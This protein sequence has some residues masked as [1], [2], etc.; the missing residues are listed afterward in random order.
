[1][2]FSFS[3]SKISPKTWFS[4]SLTVLLFG[5]ILVTQFAVRTTRDDRSQAASCAGGQS[6]LTFR[7]STDVSTGLWANDSGGGFYTKVDEDFSD[8]DSTYLWDDTSG[9]GSVLILG[10]PAASLGTNYAINS[11]TISA[12]LRQVQSSS[13]GPY[14]EM[15]LRINGTLYFSPGTKY[16]PPPNNTYANTEYTWNT[17]PA[18]G[19]AWNLASVNAAN[20]AVRSTRPSQPN[21]IRLTQVWMN[22]CYS[23]IP[24]PTLNFTADSTSLSYNSATTL[25]WTA[26]N[27]TSCTASNGWSGGKNSI[28]GSEGTGNLTSP[29]TYV[30]TC[31]GGGGSIS[32]QV[33]ISVGAAPPPPPANPN[34]TPN[35]PT[36]KKPTSTKPPAKVAPPSSGQQPVAVSTDIKVTF[37]PNPFLQGLM[38]VTLEIPGTSISQKASVGKD[39]GSFV[40][41]AANILTKNT[42]Y[43]FRSSSINSLIQANSFTYSDNT[44][45]TLAAFTTGDFNNDNMIDDTDLKLL[46]PKGENTG[47]KLYDIN[48][49]GVVNSVD[50]SLL[51]ISLGKKG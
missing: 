34:P 32:R 46:V 41:A 28:S 40:I 21:A 43:V 2:P 31:S 3:K 26:T 22:S 50:Y 37:A 27:A 24:V 49:D 17:N 12:R 14:I 5:T 1:M 25:R 47:D 16:R 51:L 9:S 23:L 33:S 10:H 36:T 4:L 30:L 44:A 45:V 35:P 11:V 48:F 29:R 8:E 39:G 6:Q 18:T 42:S 20:I 7:P 19:A 38:G 13:T 15:G